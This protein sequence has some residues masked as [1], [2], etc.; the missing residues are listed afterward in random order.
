MWDLLSLLLMECSLLRSALTP[1]NQFSSTNLIPF[2]IFVSQLDTRISR[3]FYLTD[4][5]YLPYTLR[6]PT[7][8]ERIPFMVHSFIFSCD[9]P[10]KV[11]L[12]TPSEPELFSQ[13]FHCLGE[14][15]ELPFLLHSRP[16]GSLIWL[17]TNTGYLQRGSC[18]H[19]V[20]FSNPW[21]FTGVPDPGTIPDLFHFPPI[22]SSHSE[23]SSSPCTTTS[24]A[25]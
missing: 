3:S 22:N 6:R 19:L 4:S 12:M 25:P 11:A 1:S 7:M 20:T 8:H 17:V 10:Q 13:L 2:P 18:C 16:T 9:S 14:T 24:T 15:H 23:Q 21:G 5:H